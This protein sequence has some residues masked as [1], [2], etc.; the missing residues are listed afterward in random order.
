MDLAIAPHRPIQPL[1]IAVDDEGQ[2]VELLARRERE[3]R[4]R[5]RFVH[6]TVAEDAPN[7][8]AVRVQ[9]AAV[10]QIAHEAGLVD[11]ADWADAHGPCRRLPEVRHQPGMGIG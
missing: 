4:G 8:S 5:F 3:A 6:L 2:V 7:A 1:E 10:A 9:E 11:G